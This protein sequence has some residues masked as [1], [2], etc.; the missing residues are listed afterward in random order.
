MTTA[1]R[2]EIGLTLGGCATLL[3]L[4]IPDPESTFADYGSSD[5]LGNGQER[6]IGLP[7]VDWHYGFM[8]SAQYTAM[9]AFCSDISASV[10]IA[11]P[12]TN[13]VWQRYNAIMKLPLKFNI[14]DTRYI[15]FVIHFTNLVAA[16]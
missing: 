3:S 12:K 2:Y 9:K 6:G 16:E 10:V 5:L 1:T 4:R 14:R 13:L 15:D 11:T 8:T 7:Q